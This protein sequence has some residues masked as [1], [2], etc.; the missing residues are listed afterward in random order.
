MQ[1]APGFRAS[2]IRHLLDW[3]DGNNRGRRDPAYGSTVAYTS[4]SRTVL[5]ASRVAYLAVG[6]SVHD[7][8]VRGSDVYRVW[9]Q[10]LP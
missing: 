1:G 10:T 9:G 8:G 6:Y 3:S 7:E 2:S 4:V 5:G